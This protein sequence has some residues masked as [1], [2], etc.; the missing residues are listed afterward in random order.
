[1]DRSMGVGTVSHD[2]SYSLFKWDDA[3]GRMVP[4]S[5]NLEAVPKIARRRC[6]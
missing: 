4:F 2:G 5:A 6:A 1:L 3:K